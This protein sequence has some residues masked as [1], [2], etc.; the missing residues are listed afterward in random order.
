[1]LDALREGQAIQSALTTAFGADAE[2]LERDWRGS[3]PTMLTSGLPRNVMDDGNLRPAQQAAADQRWTDA[4]ALAR[5]AE[6]FWRN[7]GHAG[8]A[9]EARGLADLADGVLAFRQA[10]ELAQQRLA[11]RRYREAGEITALGLQRLPSQ[12]D[13]A[14]GAQLQII[15]QRAEAGLQGEEALEL[16]RA[17]MDAYRIIDAQRLAGQAEQQLALAGDDAR[18]AEAREIRGRA[19][20]MQQLLATVALAVALLS[21]GAYWLNRSRSAPPVRIG[22]PRREVQ[23]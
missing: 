5:V 11:E 1:L 7:V 15:A 16:A 21:G 13:A 2:T 20:G 19:Q 4:A 18:A 23:L 9:E 8:H 12:A 10:D 3:I 17:H 6:Q 22:S 14:Y